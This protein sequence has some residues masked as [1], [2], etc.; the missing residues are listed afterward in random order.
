MQAGG[1]QGEILAIVENMDVGVQLAVFIQPVR[2]DDGIQPGDPLDR[3]QN[4]GAL[5]KFQVDGFDPGNQAE[6]GE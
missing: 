6:G 3:F 4:G 1:Q 2:A 5:R